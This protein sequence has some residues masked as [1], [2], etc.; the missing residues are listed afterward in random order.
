M[1]P[2]QH[3]NSQFTLYVTKSEIFMC[4]ADIWYFTSSVSLLGRRRN[5][6][7]QIRCCLTDVENEFHFIF[8]PTFCEELCTTLFSE[9]KLDFVNL[10]MQKDYVGYLG[11]KIANVSLCGWPEI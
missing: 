6:D 1:G 10:M 8:L 2:V 7:L 11:N 5:A 4:P 3:L 9:G